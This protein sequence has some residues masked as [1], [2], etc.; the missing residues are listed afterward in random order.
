[1]KKNNILVG[2]ACI[3]VA[4][5]IVLSSMGV[6]IFEGFSFWTVTLAALTIIWLV[7]GVAHLHFFSIFFP[8]AILAILFDK[9]LGIENFTPWPVLG[10]ALCFSIGFESVF[11]PMIR[12]HRRSRFYSSDGNIHVSKDGKTVTIGDG[13]QVSNDGG[14]T[15]SA[16]SSSAGQ[17]TSSSFAEKASFGERVKY[18]NSEDFRFGSI[19]C[20]FGSMQV[21]FDNAKVPTG[22]CELDI[23][24][25]FA[26]V[27]LYIPRSWVVINK[28]SCTLGGVDEKGAFS[29]NEASQVTITLSGKASFS[30]IEIIR[31]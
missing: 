10:I 24:S 21:Y 23:S 25:A 22:H 4:A 29:P 28:M 1:M 7:S 9:Q 2:I 12:K 8:I 16:F 27:Q 6:G 18:V 11:G 19:D 3:L 17:T 30:G 5:V 26:G 20:S 14:E 31:V 15:S 13:V